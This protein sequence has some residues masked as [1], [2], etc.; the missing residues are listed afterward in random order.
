[1]ECHRIPLIVLGMSQDS[2]DSP[3][4]VHGMSMECPWN[5]TECPWNVHGILRNVCGM[6]MECPTDSGRIPTQD[7][8]ECN[9]LR[10]RTP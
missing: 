5:S 9:V 7:V 1:M 6:S 4:N 10:E 2:V 8:G 3:W